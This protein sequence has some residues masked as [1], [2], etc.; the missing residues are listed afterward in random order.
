MRQRP[1][2]NLGGRL[3]L[4]FCVFDMKTIVIAAESGPKEPVR[5]VIGSITALERT[6]SY[7]W[8]AWSIT[9][10]A[11]SGVFIAAATAW[12]DGGDWTRDFFFAKP[13][14]SFRLGV[15]NVSTSLFKPH[16]VDRT[17]RLRNGKT[18]VSLAPKRLSVRDVSANREL[19]FREVS[20][21]AKGVFVSPRGEYLALFETWGNGYYQDGQV[22]FFYFVSNPGLRE[23]LVGS[24]VPEPRAFPSMILEVLAECEPL[25]DN[26]DKRVKAAQERLRALTRGPYEKEAEWSARQAA[27]RKEGEEE[28][29]RLRCDDAAERSACQTRLREMT[30]IPVEVDRVNLQLGKYDPDL[31][32]FSLNYWPVPSWGPTIKFD[33]NL[34]V[35]RDLAADFKARANSLKGAATVVLNTMM[36]PD[37]LAIPDRGVRDPK[38]RYD[39]VSL[40]IVDPTSK[41]L[42]AMEPLVFKDLALASVP[43]SPGLPAR[44]NARLRWSG[45]KPFG[46]GALDAEELGEL[47]VDVTNE[48]EGAARA[49]TVQLDP[50]TLANVAYPKDLPLETIGPGQTKSVPIP[51]KGALELAEGQTKLTV[52]VL[53]GAGHDAQPVVFDLNTRAI[54]PPALRVLDDFDVSG[55]FKGQL[56][57]RDVVATVRLRVRNAGL[58]IARGVVARVSPGEGISRTQDGPDRFEIGTLNPGETKQFEYRCYANRRAKDMVLQVDLDEERPAYTVAGTTVT[59]PL[60]GSDRVAQVVSI[61]P[62]GRKE[63]T[64]ASAPAPLT[65]DVDRDVPRSL[66]KR[67]SGLAVVMG[68]EDYAVGPRA[69]FAGDDA[70]TAATYAEHILGI[71]H[72]RILLLRDREA[73]RAQFD[74]V[75][76]EGGWLSRRV[77]PDSEIFVFFSGHGMPE[78]E[79]ESAYLM[80]ADGDPDYVKQT[81]FPLNRMMEAIAALHARRASVFLDAC[82]TGMSRDGRAMQEGARPVAVS[83]RPTWSE[84]LAVYSAAKGAQIASSLEDQ[85]HGIFSYYLFKGLGGEADLN[86]D[87][88]LTA[89]ELKKY[90]E[91]AVPREAGRRDREQ[92]PDIRLMEPDAVLA[93]FRAE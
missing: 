9:E 65:S 72:D 93:E 8:K 33:G 64:I 85:R 77:Q 1:F 39:V 89:A 67:P 37:A 43:S 44:L 15:D 27:A 42:Y 47:L 36:F 28:I 22:V 13:P 53:E 35:R 86:G 24:A 14:S 30:R 19:F 56:V 84:G 10:D 23:A 34:P 48:G 31:E 20:E 55:S 25:R 74:K 29:A 78:I 51:F 66:T 76:D 80:P 32:Q 54:V 45:E 3:L 69:A 71:P 21:A 5:L 18:V 58:G 4:L 41:E 57:P 79:G 70:T 90:L 6:N 52:R 83:V 26:L 38:K 68:V 17:L 46:D 40:R 82:F 75:F 87:K 16:L 50:P 49:V 60:E 59:V 2:R 73:T 61:R 12:P 62:D 88:R 81:A 11:N 7:P 91:I 92:E 63:A